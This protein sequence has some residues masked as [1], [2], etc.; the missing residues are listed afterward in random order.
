[1]NDHVVKLNEMVWFEFLR[2]KHLE[3]VKREFSLDISIPKT[4]R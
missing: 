1:M 4:S 3:A 2:K